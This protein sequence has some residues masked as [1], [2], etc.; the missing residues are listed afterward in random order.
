MTA[1]SFSPG[2]DGVIATDSAVSWLDEE[3][4][5]IVIR[6]YDL[7]E[8][9]RNLNYVDVAYLVMYGDLPDV[10]SAASFCAALKEDAD[11]PDDVYRV[12][13]SMPKGR[14]RHGRAAHRSLVPRGPRRSRA[15]GR[16]LARRES[17]KG[18]RACWRRGR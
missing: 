15:P 1:Q 17:G 7:I 9:A 2:L 4:E 5:Q 8:L 6:G 11:V 18:R 3:N 14:Q 16:H 12:L 10:E 13:E